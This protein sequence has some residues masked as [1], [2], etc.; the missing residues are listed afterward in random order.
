MRAKEFIT[1]LNMAPGNLL[2]FLQTPIAKSIR[3][4]FEAELCFSRLLGGSVPDDARTEPDFSWDKDITYYTDIGDIQDFFNVSKLNFGI[5]K[6]S[7]EYDDE[8]KD[9]FDLYKEDNIDREIQTVEIENDHLDPEDDADQIYDIAEE[10]LRVAFETDGKPSLMEF[11]RQNKIKTMSD[12]SNEYS[13]DWPHHTKVGESEWKSSAEEVQHVI[14]KV[15]YQKVEV[16]TEYH[17]DKKNS[18]TWYIEPD[19]SINGEN[20]GHFCAEIVSPPMAASSIIN[21]MN[22]VFGALKQH[23]GAYTNNST[24]LHIGVSID[25]LNSSSLDYVK[26]ALFLGDQYVLGQFGRQSSSFARSSLADI[27]N[28]ASASPVLNQS[29]LAK[30]K[31]G[32]ADSASKLIASKNQTRN[33]TIN[34]R[35]NYVE[36]RAMGS[37]YLSMLPVVEST[38]LRYIRA[39][40]VAM[41]PM[42]ER[43]EY[44]KKLT[45]ML[46][47]SGVDDPLRIFV[48]YLAG[49]KTDIQAVKAVLSTRR[50]Q[51]QT[52]TEPDAGI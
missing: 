27:I 32:M 25:G 36:F 35:E 20:S 9:E 46:N 14:N 44:A 43:Q 22:T 47:P 1:E 3:V 2:A 7:E 21:R 26:L 16:F 8:V 18:S 10:K 39:Y 49:N 45:K 48:D 31:A 52:P 30:V 33:M 38:V 12:I 37:D 17:L 29:I 51:Q 28:K 5:M 15:A 42:A 11:F 13:F 6:I 40:A 23:F 4:G 34:V 41:D 24:G 19:G 50:Q